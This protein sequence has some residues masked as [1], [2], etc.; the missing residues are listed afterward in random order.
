MK[1]QSS[2]EAQIENSS[3]IYN[4]DPYFYEDGIIRVGER[5]DRSNLNNECKHSI[6]LSKGSPI[7]KLKIAW[8]HKKS[9]HTGRRMIL[10]EIRT[11]GFWIGRP[12][13]ATRKFIHYCVVCK[14]LRE[15]L[16]GTKNGR[17]AI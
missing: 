14:S 16:K 15:I 5:L 1:K 10:N 13:Y 3:Q 4:L 7:S 11:S 8:C 9:G 12:N 6:V 2:K 17:T